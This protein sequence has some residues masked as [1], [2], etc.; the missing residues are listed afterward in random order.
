[1]SAEAQRAPAA[2]PAGSQRRI[3]RAV[4]TIGSITLAV[5]TAGILKHLL[6]AWRF[7]TSDQI[8]CFL[9]ALLLPT[10]VT[11]VVESAFN[12]AFIPAFVAIREKEGHAAGQRLF[13][14]VSSLALLALAG[15]T[16]VFVLLN[17]PILRGIA[18][19]F[20]D[21]KIDLT[22]RLFAW[23]LPLFPL[24][25]ISAVWSAA[26]N[27]TGRFAAAAVAPLFAPLLPVLAL[28]FLTGRFGIPALAVASVGGAAL[29]LAVVGWALRRRGFQLRPRL[30]F[31]DPAVR[32][33]VA[34]LWPMLA[35]AMIMS[36]STL[37]DQAVAARL[38]AGS[39]AALTYGNRIIA[40]GVSLAAL[41][42]GTALLPHLSQMVAR[43]EYAA[44]RHTL[45][46]WARLIALVVAP[47]T[48]IVVCLSVPITRL[49]LQRGAFSAEDTLLVA[50][51][52][53]LYAL[54]APFYVLGILGVRVLSALGKNRV[55]FWVSA[56]NV[57]TNFAGDLLFM[58]YLGLPGIAL[59]TS[60]VYFISS[61]VI[62]IAVRR[63]L[64][65][66]AP[67]D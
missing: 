30:G 34:Q 36:S 53:S 20:A 28:I 57:I 63:H 26:L 9:V 23:M 37:I 51:V 42:L 5:R 66:A 7:G 12:A 59:S 43:N 67:C 4:L 14:R 49:L 45:K 15:L 65:R 8:D 17:G 31:A 32:Q 19:G 33:V 62:F 1:M 64:P 48:A 39:V 60:V 38:G 47:A 3:L 46:T 50:R 24:A 6:I 29:Q 41:S 61:A 21:G 54:Q 16:L 2:V 55:L 10:F 11:S 40:F 56:L 13:A 27:A 44:L 52:Q 18:A 22:R 58:R 25:G 35:G